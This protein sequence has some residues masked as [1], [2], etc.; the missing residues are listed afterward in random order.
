MDRLVEGLGIKGQGT[1]SRHRMSII[2][3]ITLIFVVFCLGQSC[4]SE[5]DG[6]WSFLQNE[7]VKIGIKKASGGAIGWFSLAD[8]KDNLVNHFDH[9]RLIQQSY[10]GRKDGSKWGKKPWRW[11]PVQGGDY[12]GHPAK[13]IEYKSTD[14]SLYV[15]TRPKHWANGDDINEVLMEERITL[16]GSV[17]HIEFRMTYSGSESHPRR[18][19]EIPALFVDRSLGTLLID[20]GESVKE[21]QPGFPNER[22]P[23]PRHW[24]AYVNKDDFGLGIYVPQAEELTCYRVGDPGQK[25]ACSYLAPLAVFAITPGMVFEYDCYLTIGKRDQIHQ[26]FTSLALKRK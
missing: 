12:L 11:N 13:I 5:D 2:S 3:K 25:G 10:Y 1:V 24:A 21:F 9:G 6:G 15:K 20:Q 23:T 19:Q 22:Y 18:D 14:S 4:L 8:S 16:L 7:H 17:A 26:R